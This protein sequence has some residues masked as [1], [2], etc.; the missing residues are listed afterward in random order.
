MSAIT[1]YIVPSKI[2]GSLMKELI[3]RKNLSEVGIHAD[4]CLQFN[5]TLLRNGRIA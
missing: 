1:V 2:W 4:F 5:N 3:M